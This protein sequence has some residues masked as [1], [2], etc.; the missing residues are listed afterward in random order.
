MQRLYALSLTLSFS[1]QKFSPLVE[2]ENNLNQ[3]G[4]SDVMIG[5]P[6]HDHLM[7]GGVENKQPGHD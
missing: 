3:R 5:L 2:S 1:F 7:N 6:R 4:L